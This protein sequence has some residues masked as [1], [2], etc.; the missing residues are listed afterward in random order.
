MFKLYFSYLSSLKVL[1][2]FPVA[3]DSEE[4]AFALKAAVE[5]QP[6]VDKLSSENNF[7]REDRPWH[8]FGLPRNSR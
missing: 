4:A 5:P 8:P 3:T 2:L 6:S 7:R 1:K